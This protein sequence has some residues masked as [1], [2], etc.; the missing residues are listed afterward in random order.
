VDTPVYGHTALIAINITGVDMFMINRKALAAVGIAAAAVASTALISSPAEAS[1]TGTAKVVGRGE[2][3][4]TAAK[5]KTNALVVTLSGRTVTLN[6]K[7]AIKAG[8]GCK[9]VKGDKTKVKCT[10]KWDPTGVTVSLSDKNDSVTNKTWLNLDANGG[11]GNDVLIG[12]AGVDSLYGG[13]GNDKLYGKAN[14]DYLYG[15]KGNDRLDGGTDNDWLQGG[16]GADI[17][18]GGTGSQDIVDYI[19]RTK[20]VTADIDGNADDGEKGEKDVIQVDIEWLLGGRGADTLTGGSAANLI[21]GGRG[22]DVIR[23]GG[24]NDILVGDYGSDKIYG[25]AGDD[26][27]FG[28]ELAPES[29]TAGSDL[30]K[31]RIDG[32]TNTAIGDTC[33]YLAAGSSVDCEHLGGEGGPETG[34]V[35]AAVTRLTK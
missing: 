24:G 30:A 29:G 18:R 5:G 3:V 10:T 17:F 22:N 35:A 14:E 7:V 33:Y 28:E 25:E 20:P 26:E 31:D 19:A 27:V 21:A 9:A 23:G 12:G 6:D 16:A 13:D 8:K 32:G 1:T 11:P 2:V 34:L 4:F 15:D